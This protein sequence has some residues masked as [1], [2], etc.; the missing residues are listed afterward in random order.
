MAFPGSAHINN[1]KKK[2]IN[3]TDKTQYETQNTKNIDNK[4]KIV[5]NVNYECAYVTVM[6]VIIFPL[7]LQTV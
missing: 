7:I 1:N 6:A 4:P 5:R 3:I 2:N